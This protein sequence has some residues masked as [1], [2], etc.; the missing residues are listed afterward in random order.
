MRH[1][2]LLIRARSARG[3]CRAGAAQSGANRS[4]AIEAGAAASGAIKTG[5]PQAGRHSSPQSTGTA[6]TIQYGAILRH[7]VRV[8]DPFVRPADTWLIRRLAPDCSRIEIESLPGKRD[9]DRLLYSMGWETAN[10]HLGSQRDIARVKRDLR[11]RPANWLHQPAKQMV[12]CVEQD[13]RDWRSSKS[14]P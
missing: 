3:N 13:W 4:G 1:F 10:I 5:A 8:L 2:Q 11:K 6:T 14:A 9:E 7:A 12:Q